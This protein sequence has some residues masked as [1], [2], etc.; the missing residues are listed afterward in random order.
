MRGIDLTDLGREQAATTAARLAQVNIAT[1]YSSPIERT[2][3]TATAIAAHHNLAVQEC[4]GVI[5]AEYGDWTDCELKDLA[6]ADEW[7]VV[8]AAPSRARFP[9]GESITEMQARMVAAL[10]ELVAT[11]RNE[12]IVVVSHADPIKS[13]IAHFTGVHLDLFQ[14]IHVAPASV[15]VFEFHAYGVMMLKCNDTGS[16]DELNSAPA[17]ASPTEEDPAGGSDA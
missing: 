1:I 2:M 13:A 9:G 7:K 14:R 15:T 16:L 17:T 3:Q 11:H 5:E 4:E 10:N 6:K 8:Q 12:T